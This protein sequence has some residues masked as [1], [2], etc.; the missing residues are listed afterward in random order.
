VPAIH[1]C[2][3]ALSELSSLEDFRLSLAP[4]YLCNFLSLRSKKILAL[5]KQ[6]PL[7]KPPCLFAV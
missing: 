5:D 3:P 2:V 7:T 4:N 1:L 6:H